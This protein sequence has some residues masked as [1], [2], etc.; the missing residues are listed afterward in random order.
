[1][2]G[3]PSTRTEDPRSAKVAADSTV[4]LPSIP[5]VEFSILRLAPGPTVMLPW[6]STIARF[7]IVAKL[8]GINQ[9]PQD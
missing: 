9:E 3:I 5:K 1:M 7:T 8:P 2:R 4:R 6:T